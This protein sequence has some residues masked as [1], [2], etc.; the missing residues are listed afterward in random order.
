MSGRAAE[1]SIDKAAILDKTPSSRGANLS[2]WREMRALARVASPYWWAPPALL[3]LGLAAAVA[4]GVSVSLVVLFL[5]TVVGRAVDA[6]QSGGP[7]GHVFRAA[8]ALVGPSSTALGLLIFG[9]VLLRTALNMAYGL[10]TSYVK[11]RVAE[12]MRVQVHRQYLAVSY[13]YI[14]RHEYADMLNVLA[15]ESWSVP[16]AY[17]VV[18]RIA[19][20]VCGIAVFGVFLLALSWQLT[21][22]AVAG[23]V[24]VFFLTQRFAGPLRRLYEEAIGLNNRLAHRMLTTLQCMRAIRAF[25]QETAD[26]ERF[27]RASLAV[28]ESFIRMGWAHAFVGPIGDIGHLAVLGSIAAAAGPLGIPAAVALAAIALLYRLQPQVQELQG[29]WLN[30]ATMDPSLRQVRSVLD[31]RDKTY[32][33]QGERPFVRLEREIRFEGVGLTYPGADRPSLVDVSFAIPSGSTVALVGPS[34]SGKTSLVNLL[35]RLY[36]PDTGRITVDGTPLFELKRTDW[37]QRLAVAGQDV[38]LVDGTLREN[39][40]MGRPERPGRREAAAEAAGMTDFVHDTH[41]GFDTW[42]GE[43]GLHLSGGQRQRVGLARALFGEPQ[44]LILDEAT[45]ALDGA[46]EAE[47][48]R[49]IDRHAQ[50]RTLILV[51]HR[52]HSVLGAD[53][54]VCIVD[55]R[56]VEQGPPQALMARPDG[57]LRGMIE[58]QDPA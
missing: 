13:D 23:S 42:I 30:L 21:A 31:P 40:T 45:S 41:E 55:G 58:R 19:I 8:Q 10:V 37:L 34:G 4:D 54:V 24:L 12:D 26:G 38:E 14:Q 5:Y 33:P 17:Y 32:L 22:I 49:S 44:I 29:N 6:V 9:V 43:R 36:A 56:V 11:N 53:R 27:V 52:L 48:R 28:R 15:K 1:H 2:A 18:T 47:V 25:A 51:T 35:L 50:G 46:L 39:I 20:N 7:V 16:D 57:V 3:A